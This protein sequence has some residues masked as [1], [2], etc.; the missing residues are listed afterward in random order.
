MSVV[1]AADLFGGGMSY[2]DPRRAEA[3][4]AEAPQEPTVVATPK[5]RPQAAGVDL[6]TVRAQLEARLTFIQSELERLES[7]DDE[8]IKI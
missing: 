2:T 4:P 8:R 3:H 6:L 1:D 7:L 5:P